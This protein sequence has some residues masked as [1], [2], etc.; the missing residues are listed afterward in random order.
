MVGSMVLNRG[1]KGRGSIPKWRGYEGGY[2]EEKNSLNSCSTCS[3]VG[4]WSYFTVI[5]NILQPTTSKY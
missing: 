5:C 1:P 4:F 2:G 3:L